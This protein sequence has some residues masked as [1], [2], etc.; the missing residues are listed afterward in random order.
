MVERLVDRPARR[1]RRRHRGHA[2]RAR[3]TCPIRCR[4]RPPRSI[5]GPATRPPP[6]HQGR[7]RQPRPHRADLPA[8]RNLRRLRAPASGDARA[9]AIGSAP[10]STEAL[11]QAGLDAAGRRSDRRPWRGTPPRRLPRAARHARRA[12]GRVRRAQGA[13]RGGDRPLPDPGAGP[14]R[15]DRDRLGDRRGARGHAQAARHPGD[16]DR[17]RPR[18]RR[19]RIGTADRR[20]GMGDLAAIAERRRLARLTRHGEI[21]AQRASADTADRPHPASSL[22]PGAFLQ[23]TAAGEAVLARL[24]EAHCTGRENGRRPVLRRRTIRVAARRTRARHRGRQRRRPRSR[25]CSAPRPGRKASSRSRRRSATSSA[26]RSCRSSS[27]GFDAVVFDPPRQ[28]AEAQARALAA[29]PV[30]TVVA[31]S[32]NP[33]TFARDARILVDGGYRLVR[34]TPVDQF[35]YSAHVE[36][37]ACFQKSG[38]GRRRTER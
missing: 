7:Q 13:S 11:A 17:C 30:P 26:V 3:S 25:P 2:A 6:S 14:R 5:S 18:C 37:V 36:L 20:P 35:L 9:I 8:F 1:A 32:C 15:R 4:A 29:S 27:S 22:P 38:E 21:V 16:G 31:V 34:V 24:V 10:W 12:R 19:A 33:A 23:A 28:G